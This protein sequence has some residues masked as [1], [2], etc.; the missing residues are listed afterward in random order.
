VQEYQK[1]AVYFYKTFFIVGTIVLMYL[2]F[3]KFFAYVLPFIIAWI[4]AL[5]VNP[6]VNRLD[7]KTKIP[8]GLLSI[9]FILLFFSLISLLLFIGA[10]RLIVELNN[11]LERLPQYAY[12]LRTAT[13][14]LIAW[15]QNIYI[16]LSPEFMQ[17]VNTGFLNIINSITAVISS[18]IGKSMVLITFFPKTLL[19]VIV[20]IISSYMM[21]KDM[22]LI[23]NFSSSQLPED[24]LNRIKSVYADLLKAL[25]GFIRAQLTIMGITFLITITGLYF[26]GIPYALTMAIIIGA[27]DALPI[28]GTGAVLVPWSIINMLMKNYRIGIPLLILYGVIL[29]TRQIIEPKIMGRNIGLHPLATLI[30]LYLGLRIFGVIGILIGPLTLIIIKAL[31]KTMLLPQWK[32][33]KKQP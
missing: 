27:V 20:T 22:Y 21:S 33:I 9:C 7:K 31:Q 5:I 26:I 13:E 19:F 11:I 16:N 8:R 14:E 25:G 1:Y 6:L 10:S 30:S 3:A 24:L 12:S 18:T 32:D 15:G 29:V 2:F 28:L 23:R 17:M 4:I